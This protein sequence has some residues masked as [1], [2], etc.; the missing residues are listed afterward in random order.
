LD[1]V[2]GAVDS[3]PTAGRVQTDAAAA[4]V[5]LATAA[6]GAVPAIK[7]YTLCTGSRLGFDGAVFVEA[8]QGSVQVVNDNQSLRVRGPGGATVRCRRL[9]AG[10]LVCNG[11]AAGTLNPKEEIVTVKLPALPAEWKVTVSPDGRNVTATG[12]G[13]LPLKIQAPNA[14]NAKVNGVDRW[15]VRDREGNLYPALEAG[16]PFPY[17]N[18]RTLADLQKCLVP[19][20]AAALGDLRS[21]DPQ[22]RMGDVLIAESGVLAFDLNTAGPGIYGIKLQLMAEKPGRLTVAATSGKVAG[23]ALPFEIKTGMNRVSLAKQKLLHDKL[24]LKLAG[25]GRLG[26]VSMMLT[27]EYRFLPANLWLTVGPFPSDFL[28]DRAKD[29]NTAVKSALETVQKPEKKPQPDAAYMGADG[30][31]IRWEHS[32]SLDGAGMKEGVN[33]A[34]RCGFKNSKIA[35]ART[36]ITAPEARS[37]QVRIS[38]DYWANLWVNGEKVT[39]ERN[40]ANAAGDGAQFNG[41]S[42][43]AANIALRKGANTILVKVQGGSGGSSFSFAITDPGDLQVTARP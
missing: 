30:K 42:R 5:S 28:T 36:T 4:V 43:T 35:Y 8:D 16:T 40:P 19:G 6:E 20:S 17:A 33:L 37:A 13:P 26:L 38:C 39:S 21:F 31:E 22:G 15:F 34:L 9:N 32:D 25:D 11:V 27:P 41:T 24:A 1:L 10:Q 18:Q 7:G 2:A 23:E 12:N 3:V 14:I 29:A